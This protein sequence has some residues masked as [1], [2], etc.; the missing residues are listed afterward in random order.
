M[1]V[2]YLLAVLGALLFISDP[3]KPIQQIIILNLPTHALVARIVKML[4]AVAA[5]FSFASFHAC[6]A[7]AGASGAPERWLGFDAR[8][9][10][11]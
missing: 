2:L 11:G 6:G 5:T 8:K 9:Y 10:S 7:D 1:L 4:N 3:T